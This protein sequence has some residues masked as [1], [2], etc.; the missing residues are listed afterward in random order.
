MFAY[1]FLGDNNKV[2]R[3]E[4][5]FFALI[6]NVFVLNLSLESL[7]TRFIWNLIIGK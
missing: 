5:G 3:N 6:L 7:E 1:I 4:K 2:A